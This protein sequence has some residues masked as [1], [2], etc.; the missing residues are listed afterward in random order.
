MAVDMTPKPGDMTISLPITFDYRGGRSG[1]WKAKIIATIIIVAAMI[2]LPVLVGSNED[3]TLVQKFIYIPC[4]IYALLFILRFFVYREAYF[5][6]L[7]E[8]LIADDYDLKLDYIWQI[9]DIDVTYP[10]TVYFRNGQRGI[11]VRME[12]D[13]ITGKPASNVFDHFD[14]IGNAYNLCHSL[15]MNMIHI[16]Y[17]DNVGNDPRV[18]TLYDELSLVENP[19]MQEMLI[20]IYNNIREEMS[21]NYASFDIYLFLTR[22]NLKNFLYNVQAVSEAMLSGNFITYKILNRDEIARICTSLFNLH[23]FSVLSACEETMNGD[24]HYGIIPLSITHADGSIEVLNKTVAEKNRDYQLAEEAKKKAK[25]ERHAKRHAKNKKGKSKINNGSSGGGNLPSESGDFTSS[26]G[27]G[28]KQK[29]G[30]KQGK[31][32][33]SNSDVNIPDDNEDIGLF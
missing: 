30:R 19:D 15:N 20:D 23:E 16:D 13:A 2:A 18:D 26:S 8:N 32:V 17:M 14:S 33:N 25:D 3:L 29:S 21:R 11:F 7:Y 10:Y 6:K 1:N 22:D 31:N 27:G 9:F 12:K 28:R 24:V 5:S 4:I